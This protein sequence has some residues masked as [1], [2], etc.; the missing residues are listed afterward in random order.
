[1]SPTNYKVLKRQFLS[2]LVCCFLAI[3]T[4]AQ[5]QYITY[6]S[7]IN[8]AESNLVHQKFRAA[9]S[10][11]AVAFNLD[12]LKP[13]NQDY[14][15]AAINA[16]LLNDTALIIRYLQNYAQR[17]GDYN[18]LK[19]KFVSNLLL[20]KFAKPILAFIKLPQNKALKQKMQQSFKN[21]KQ[22]LNKTIC[23]KVNRIYSSD[24]T[25]ARGFTI[26][27]PQKYQ[28]KVME[29]TDRK[30]AHLLIALCKTYGWPGFNL[31]GEFK[32]LGKY[33]LSKINILIRHFTQAELDSIKPD[34]LTAIKNLNAAPGDWAG[35]LDYSAIK[36]PS[37]VDSLQAYKMKQK[38]GQLKNG[39]DKLAQLIPFGKLEDVN[40]AR[41]S[42]YLIN[43]NDYCKLINATLPD[44]EFLLIPKTK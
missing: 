15:T 35:A 34:V 9:D 44:K 11:F 26:F 18:L 7:S 10:C 8:N 41:A 24:Q 2:L 32:P 30:N 5:P 22:T 33:S 3:A 38:Y 14:L 39:N 43:I 29:K 17:G 20:Q 21:Y 42:L 31:V 4:F 19:Q 40:A 28:D 23:K 37:F 6:Y 25:V 1:M 13:F 16:Y 36:Q 27:L 12:S